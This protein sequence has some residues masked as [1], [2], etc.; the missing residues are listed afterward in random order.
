MDRQGIRQPFTLCF[1]FLLSHLEAGVSSFS[2][3][4][5]I[6]GLSQVAHSR[7]IAVCGMF[8]F[9]FMLYSLHL[10]QS[11]AAPFSTVAF[12]VFLVLLFVGFLPG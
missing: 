1:T 6:E 10:R 7:Y 4:A 2:L 12:C 8:C 9:D 3:C 11:A 5:G